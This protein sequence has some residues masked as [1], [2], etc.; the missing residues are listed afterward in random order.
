MPVQI[1]QVSR[2]LAAPILFVVMEMLWVQW[3]GLKSLRVKTFFNNE[4]D[5]LIDEPDSIARSKGGET[6]NT[7]LAW[8]RRECI[9]IMDQ[10]RR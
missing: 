2:N 1:H 4:L 5:T 10:V 7:V 6:F 8:I 3:R 9:H